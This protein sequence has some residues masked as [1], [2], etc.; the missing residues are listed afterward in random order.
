MA[1]ALAVVSVVLA[2]VSAVQ[3]RK[4]AKVQRKQ[5]EVANRIAANQRIRS[6]KRGIAAGR[7][8]R[9]EI[10][11]AGF[12]GG[13]S[14]GS[15]VSGATGALASDVSSAQG[16]SAQQFTGQLALTS[17][18]NQISSIQS[19]AATTAAGSQ[20]AG[21]LSQPQTFEAITNFNPFQTQ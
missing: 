1:T 11:A 13:V 5:N 7:V 2:G 3:Q 21:G 20:I 12:R 4:A 18:S 9:G 6:V 15:A 14:G 19:R 16:A 8:R 17:L 10:I